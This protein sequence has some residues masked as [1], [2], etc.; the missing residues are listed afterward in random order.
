MASRPEQLDD[1]PFSVFFVCTGNRARSPLAAELFR[2]RIRDTDAIVDSMGTL[3][4]DS[5]PALPEAV[6]AGRVLGVDIA[7][8]RSRPISRGSLAGA[9]LVLG[10]EPFHVACSIVDGGAA[11]EKT[12]TLPELDALLEGVT[13]PMTSTGR[14]RASVVVGE[15]AR[16]RDEAPR[17]TPAS[18]ADPYGQ[19]QGDFDRLAREIDALTERLAML[20][21]AGA[22]VGP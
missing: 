18:L 13:L 14:A 19:A 8:H 10:F 12:F 17:V 5:L 11:P 7:E 21:F 2:L 16:L 1:R 22:P 3:E 4:V 6:R 15:A 9:D 20:L